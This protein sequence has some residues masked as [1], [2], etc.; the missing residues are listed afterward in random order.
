MARASPATHAVGEAGCALVTRH[1]QQLPGDHQPLDLARALAD[2]GELHVPEEL[3]RRVVLHEPVAAVDLD[4]V[5]GGLARRSRWHRAS[6][7]PTRRVVSHAPVLQ[8]R[9]RGRS[10]AA[11]PRSAVALSASFHWIAWKR[12]IGSG[13][14]RGAR[15]RSRRAASNAPCAS[16]TDERRDADA[17]GVEHLHGLD[18]PLPS[19]PMS[20]VGRHAAVLEQHLARVA[21][22]H[23][24]L[25]LLLAGAQARRVPRSTTNAEMPR[26]PGRPVGHRHRDQHVARRGRAS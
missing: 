10:A 16:P 20:C 15:P 7:S 22:P 17:P 18:E 5:V 26:V 12:L 2:R 9:R 3:L 14:T 24:E 21:R 23:A 25:V 19:S 4:A 1:G 13:R 6:P 11:P 8:L